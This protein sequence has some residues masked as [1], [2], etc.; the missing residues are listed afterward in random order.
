MSRATATGSWCARDRRRHRGRYRAQVARWSSG[1]TA[2]D[3]GRCRRPPPA[4][5]RRTA[6][7]RRRTCARPDRTAGRRRRRRRRSAAMR[8]QGRR[9]SAANSA[10][11]KC[12]RPAPTAPAH[13][14]AA[15]RWASSPVLRCSRIAVWSAALQAYIVVIDD[16]RHGPRAA[17]PQPRCRSPSQRRRRSRSAAC[18]H[19]ERIALPAAAARRNSKLA[20]QNPDRRPEIRPSA[21]KRVG[22]PLAHSIAERWLA[23]RPR[24]QDCTG[25]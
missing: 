15:I 8:H 17:R 16:Q 2:A 5:R 9:R 14:L 20:P 19:P 18:R 3:R 1:S 4:A 6:A 23:W 7:A 22:G 11:P 13:R 21:A 24:W 25:R 10:Q 12:V